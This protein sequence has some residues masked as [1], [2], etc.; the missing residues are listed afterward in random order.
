MAL[1]TAA[2]IQDKITSYNYSTTTGTVTSVGGTGSSEWF[3]IKW[4]K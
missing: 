1:M 3:V 4:F 2:A